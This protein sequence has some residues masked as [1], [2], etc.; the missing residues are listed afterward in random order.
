M[1]ATVTDVTTTF[2]SVPLERPL[3]TAAFPIPAID[4]ALV[5]I[6]TGDSKFGQIGITIHI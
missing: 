6:R 4:T 5:R 1:A 3:V 2:L